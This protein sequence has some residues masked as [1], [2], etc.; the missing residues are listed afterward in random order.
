MTP[1]ICGQ[2]QSAARKRIADA[3]ERSGVTIPLSVLAQMSSHRGI[4]AMHVATYQIEA[5]AEAVDRVVSNL[6]AQKVEPTTVGD[7]PVKRGPGR[8]KK[9]A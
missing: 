5:I 6:C 4:D 1:A 3:I 7:S 9:D 8:P 2:R